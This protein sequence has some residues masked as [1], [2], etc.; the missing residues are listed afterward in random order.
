MFMRK[1]IFLIVFA[2]FSI[3]SLVFSASAADLVTINLDQFV[4]NE[5]ATISS[6]THPALF[7]LDPSVAS[8]ELTADNPCAQIKNDN[9]A[10]NWFPAM[11][12]TVSVCNDPPGIIE[13]TIVPNSD[14]Q[15]EYA[16]IT[17]RTEARFAGNPSSFQ[18]KFSEDSFTSTL[19]IINLASATTTSVDLTTTPNSNPFSFRWIAGNDFG[20]NGGG[21]AGFTTENLVVSDCA[22]K[23]KPGCDDFQFSRR[24]R[25]LCKKY[26]DFLKCDD[27]RFR[28]LTPRVLRQCNFIENKFRRITGFAPPCTPPPCDPEDD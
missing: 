14:T 3:M 19:A 9:G 2:Y 24:E 23:C 11:T 17:F 7:T 8:A 25:R 15:L 18:L 4:G 20:E 10:G 22:G 5:P 27:E 13:L 26:C 28:F 12:P 21:E 16:C 6:V 1:Y